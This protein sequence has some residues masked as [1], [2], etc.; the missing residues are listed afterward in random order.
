M[1]Y[2]NEQFWD[3]EKTKHLCSVPP[4]LDSILKIDLNDID[5]DKVEYMLCHFQNLWEKFKDNND[6]LNACFSIQNKCNELL[7]LWKS[8][9]SWEIMT[10]A[11][12]ENYLVELAA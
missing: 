12:D 8:K 9:I 4:N 3:Y 2:S 5:N 10:A 6:I 1:I 7:N 11:N